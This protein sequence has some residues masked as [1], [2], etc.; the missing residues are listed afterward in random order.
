MNKTIMRVAVGATA[1]G[2]VLAGAGCVRVELPKPDYTTSSGTCSLEA[3]R[4]FGLPLR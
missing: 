1:I 2:L 4:K 3:P